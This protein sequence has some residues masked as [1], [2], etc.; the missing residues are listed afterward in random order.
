MTSRD[1]V[2]VYDKTTIY[3][4]WLTVILVIV[5]WVIG[6]VGDW[7]PRGPQRTAVWSV[8]VALGFAASV[9][10][11]ARIAWRMIFG[12]S[13]PP[14][15]AGILHAA[16]EAVHYLLLVLLVAVLATGVVNASYRGFNVFG[17]WQVP[18][19]G[20]GDRATRRS[21]NEW[22]ELAAHGT[23]VLAAVH[24][25]AALLHQY[26]WRDRLIDRMWP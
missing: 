1:P 9:V 26:V 23:M 24:A 19:F 16:S 11:L 20:M 21:I 8:H 5:L 12:R 18:Q 6:M 7:F 13:L 4:H 15:N 14:A 22:H 25:A 17:V 2:V 10:V 3:L